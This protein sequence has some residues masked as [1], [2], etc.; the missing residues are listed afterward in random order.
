MWPN[1]YVS[2]SSDEHIIWKLNSSKFITIR[3]NHISKVW[4]FWSSC[5]LKTIEE[6]KLWDSINWGLAFHFLYYKLMMHQNNK[7]DPKWI[8]SRTT[9]YWFNRT[10]YQGILIGLY[11]NMRYAVHT[12]K[13]QLSTAVPKQIVETIT[14][15][16]SYLLIQNSKKS[17]LVEYIFSGE[18]FENVI[19]F[20]SMNAEWS[21]P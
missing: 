10:T 7:I 1:R 8:K 14:I 9:H 5:G 17:L 4:K 16:I 18:N 20:N 19:I 3:N 13:M 21:I 15:I 6:L 12:L 11:L 2:R